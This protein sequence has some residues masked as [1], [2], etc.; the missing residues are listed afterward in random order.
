M[1]QTEIKTG[2]SYLF[3]RTDT[4]HKKDMVGTIVTVTGRRNGGDKPQY[5]G[6][7]GGVFTGTG[8]KPKRFK[9]SNGRYANASEL[10]EIKKETV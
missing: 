10:T 2:E 3:A 5:H 1:K 6:G 9:L 4:V 8:R 7:V